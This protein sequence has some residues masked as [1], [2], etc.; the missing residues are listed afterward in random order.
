MQRYS[1]QAWHHVARLVLETRTPLSIGEGRGNGVLDQL[2]VRDANGLPAIPGS[3]LAGVLRHVF[4]RHCD[5]AA[6]VQRLFGRAGGEDLYLGASR[7]HVSW[8]CL[9]DSTDRP[10]EGLLLGEAQARLRDPLLRHAARE[11]PV[12][13]NRVRIDHRGCAGEHGLFTRTALNAGFRFSVALAYRHDGRGADDWDVLLKVLG[14]PD[15]RLGGGTH[16]GLGAFAV[17]RL[18]HGVFDLRQPGDFQKY[19]ALSPFVGDVSGLKAAPVSLD[20]GRARQ[21]QVTLTPDDFFQF[22]RGSEPLSDGDGRDPDLLPV[23]ETRVHWQGGRGV[24]G[25][26]E[27]LLPASAIKGS[28]R[29]RLAYHDNCLRRRFADADPPEDAEAEANPAVRELFGTAA[30]EVEADSERC[31]GRVL[32]DDLYRQPETAH[33][34]DHNGIDAFTGGVRRHL[35]FREEVQAGHGPIHL[36]LTVLDPEA[37]RECTRTA[38]K[39]TLL[40]LV[41]GRLGLGAGRG[42]GHGFFTGSLKWNDGGRWIEG[43]L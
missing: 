10:V 19:G 41:E 33:V 35:L 32:L 30:D 43:G 40:D 2:I 20:L 28:L 13:R 5:D 36:H 22:G 4:G 25:D 23:S 17:V 39:R 3:S 37:V 16:A 14:R 27:I 7:V 11:A 31:V 9:H 8:G 26:R 34:I 18:H 12:L 24:L 21:V 6:R 38:L 42:R 15:F 1:E 29:H